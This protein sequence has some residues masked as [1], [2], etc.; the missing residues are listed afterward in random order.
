MLSN[1]MAKRMGC[2]KRAARLAGAILSLILLPAPVL[3]TIDFT[4]LTWQFNG[5][6]A[7]TGS[8]DLGAGQLFSDVKVASSSSQAVLTFVEKT[9]GTPLSPAGD[10]ILAQL[11]ATSGT[12][13]VSGSWNTP[14]GNISAGN[15]IT[16]LST[17]GPFSTMFF[18][19]QSTTGPTGPITTSPSITTGSAI[20]I[21][22]SSSGSFTWSTSAT[23]FTLALNSP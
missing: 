13:T 7:V 23:E 2:R 22:M 6:A 9:P 5:N 14:T 15:L 4:T 18:A 21:Q 19:N 12:G 3:A 17:F 20:L 1:T 11:G 16:G 10:G 8:G